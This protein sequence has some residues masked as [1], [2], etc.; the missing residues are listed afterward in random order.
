MSF[1]SPNEKWTADVFS[2]LN[3]H[4]KFGTNFSNRL[5]SETSLPAFRH[6]EVNN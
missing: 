3:V 5:G 1:R 6:D 4:C 2:F